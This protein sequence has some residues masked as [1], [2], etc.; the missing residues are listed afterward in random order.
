MKK[1]TSFFMIFLLAF[2]LIS[3]KDKKDN[4]KDDIVI[5]YTNDIHSYIGNTKENENKEK[6]PALRLNNVSGYVKE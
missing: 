6:V 4:R 5:V 3:C 2:L 1:I